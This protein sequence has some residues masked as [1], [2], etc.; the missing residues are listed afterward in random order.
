MSLKLIQRLNQ[1][2]L[3]KYHQVVTSQQLRK[4]QRKLVFLI[5]LDYRRFIKN[6]GDLY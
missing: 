2:E 3:K 6:G 1:K 4:H 5:Y